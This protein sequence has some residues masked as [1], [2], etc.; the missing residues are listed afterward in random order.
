ME[1]INL[2]TKNRIESRIFK[3][4][5]KNN[6]TNIFKDVIYLNEF[7]ECYIII[8]KERIELINFI[9][10]YNLSDSEK[11]RH[12]RKN[13]KLINICISRHYYLDLIYKNWDFYKEKL[14]KFL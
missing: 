11:I 4:L 14:N 12:L 8:E 10:K 7:C 1:L 2:K 9:S 5:K 6:F 13:R 3:I